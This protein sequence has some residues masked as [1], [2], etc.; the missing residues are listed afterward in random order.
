[1][2]TTA[3]AGT[4][5][6]DGFVVRLRA[7]LVRADR[8]RLLV[9]GSPV[10][11]VRLSSQARRLLAGGRLT[12][13]GPATAALARRLLDGNLAD[14]VL[15]GCAVPLADLTV[16]VP[17]RDRPEQLDRCLAALVPL[18][19]V[20]VD[21]ASY[22]PVAVARVARRRGARVI[23]LSRN[24]GPAGARNAGLDQ[25]RTPLVAFVDSDVEVDAS[26]L[27]DLA[28]HCADPLVALV[29]PRVVGR[30]AGRVVG[31][32][33]GRPDRRPRWFERYDAVASSLDLGRVGGR[34]LPGAA[35]GWLPSACLVGRTESLRADDGDGRGVDGFE[36][37]WRVAEDVDLVWRLTDAGHVVR[38]DPAVEAH[39]DVRPSVRTWLGRK[40]VYGTGGADLAARHGD[41][42]APAVLS[43]PVALG[44]AAVLQR[45]WWSVPVAA[46]VV[47][48]TTRS[49]RRRLPEGEDS[50][51]V[52]ARL[53]ARGLG[54]G[55]R[56]ESALLLRHWWPAAAV[57]TVLSRSAR[58]AVLTA[59]AVD[60]A[61]FLRDRPGIDPATALAA[62]RL[63]DLAY[64]AGLWWG[65][66]RRRSPRCLAIRWTRRR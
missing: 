28:R 13:D 42:V 56:Q 32:V 43:V 50:T 11:V 57:A 51:A 2:T 40:F 19:V 63:D 53:A 59:V 58:R 22:D 5:L 26:A 8:G 52:A 66:L 55:I 60:L 37:A 46:V 3:A 45:R 12:V 18:Q 36:D 17:V 38:Y 39:H 23:A 24:R 31:R 1:M 48:A 6:P 35:I 41:K 21:D 54:W 30:V 10:R 29:G 14:P 20:V 34:V 62:R 25:V 7:D 61:V 49:V 4:A 44:A 15:D 33:V 16:V 27:L 65:A 9:G 47:A 64:G